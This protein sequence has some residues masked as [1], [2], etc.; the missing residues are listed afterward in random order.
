M[1]PGIDFKGM[2]V[3]IRRYRKAY[4]LT[5]VT[6]FGGMLFGWDTGMIG[7][8]LTL[9]AFQKSFALDKTSKDF[10]NLQGNI[11]SVLQ[12]GC[13]FGAMSSFFISEKSGRRT[14][15]FIADAIF[16]IGSI[17]QVCSGL[18]TTSLSLLYV[19]RVVGGFGVGLISAVVPSYIGENVNK[20]VR[21]RCIGTM[22]LFNVTGIML[23]YFVNYG[24]SS[25]K[26]LGAL[27]WR[28]PFTLQMLPGVLLFIGLLFQNESPRWLVEQ[29][30][31]P[32]AQ[33]ALS[34]VRAKPENDPILLQ[35]LQ[36]I[37]EDFRM[38]QRLSFVQQFRIVA[39]S[40][41]IFYQFS[42]A[43][44]LMFCQQWTGTNSINYYSPQ[45]FES[46]GLTSTSAGLFA[47]GIYGVV[48][49]VCTALGLAFATEQLGRKWSLLIGGAGQAFAMNYI[50]I[51]GAVVPHAGLTGSS[52]F[53]IVCVYLF[54][55]FYSFGWGPIP[56]VLSAECAPNHV[57][58]LILAAAL[59][60]QWLFNFVIAKLTPIM[61][62]DITYGTYLLFG[63]CCV[64]MVVYTVFCVPETKNVPLESVHLLF[65]GGIVRGATRDTLRSRTRAKE[66]QAH[67]HVKER[68]ARDAEER[69]LKSEGMARRHLEDYNV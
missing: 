66:L 59:M 51:Q 29:N 50:G 17:L 54:V 33:R 52:Y 23:S 41:P 36:E 43:I 27:Q 35:E 6:S 46:I 20:E 25:H 32:K 26:S 7:G 19:G 68:D 64:L 48:K 12:A 61:L 8:I 3:D 34:R 58:S 53:A 31:I 45:I 65:Q 63:S 55:V 28:I 44:I 47:T 15:L 40:K 56:F 30:N 62:A 67:S 42:M 49:V 24:I 13:F 16:I 5:A 1:A 37:I 4:I 21:G 14:A 18:K 39:S 10:S 69:N 60:T 2:I 22:Q 57:R 11:V 38:H 9:P